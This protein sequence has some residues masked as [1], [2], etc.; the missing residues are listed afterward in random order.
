[1]KADYHWF[2]TA[3]GVQGSSEAG[4]AGDGSQSNALGNELDITLVN[5]YNDNTKIMI[6]FSNYTTTAAFRDLRTVVGDGS[7][8]AYLQFDVRF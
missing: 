6:G 8:W 2:S 4:L 7:N 1:M 5:K 3:E